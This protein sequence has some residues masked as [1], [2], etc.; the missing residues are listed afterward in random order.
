MLVQAVC[1]CMRSPTWSATLWYT[2]MARTHMQMEVHALETLA[3][4]SGVNSSICG[5][6]TP[7]KTH[8]SYTCTHTASGM[9]C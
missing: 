6:Y 4:A 2:Y 5:R 8:V 1:D 3:T 7:S 9:S